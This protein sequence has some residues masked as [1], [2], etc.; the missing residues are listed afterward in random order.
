MQLQ[1]IATNV[2]DSQLGK[3]MDKLQQR[4]RGIRSARREV[5]FGRITCAVLAS[6][7][8]R[9][10]LEVSTSFESV[11]PIEGL[12]LSLFVVVVTAVRSHN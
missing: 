4:L 1:L 12:R 7:W 2:I 11:V 10:L 5:E 6:L 9:M 3:G 8:Q